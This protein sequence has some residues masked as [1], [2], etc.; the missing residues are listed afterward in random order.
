MKEKN[1]KI[2][3]RVVVKPNAYGSAGRYIGKS[4]TVVQ[5]G[6]FSDVWYLDIGG[7]T[8]VVTSCA[9]RKFKIGVDE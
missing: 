5:S 6:V 1:V 9:I 8:V 2:G 7:K 3:M 4:G